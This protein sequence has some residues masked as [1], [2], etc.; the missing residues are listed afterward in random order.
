MKGAKI[1]AGKSQG[2]RLVTTISVL[3]ISEPELYSRMPIKGEYSGNELVLTSFAQIADSVEKQLEILSVLHQHNQLGIIL[4]YVG[5]ILPEVSEKVIAKMDEL[6]MVLIL[7]PTNRMDLRYSEVISEALVHISEEE[8]D[9]DQWQEVLL[10]TIRQ[11]PA[12]NQI[13]TSLSILSDKFKCSLFIKSQEDEV[14][15]SKA[16]PRSLDHDLRG[17]I[18]G[19]QVNQSKKNVALELKQNYYFQTDSR[20]ALSTF[21]QSYYLS[22]FRREPIVD[23]QLKVIQRIVEKTIRYFGEEQL[24]N[25]GQQFFSACQ[26]GDFQTASLLAQKEGIDLTQPLRVHCQQ[27]VRPKKQPVY[28][29]K[30][31]YYQEQDLA[32]L[33]TNA[34]DQPNL[35]EV[36]RSESDYYFVSREFLG[37]D[38][39]FEQM[40]LIAEQIE[41]GKK[42]FPTKCYFSSEDLYLLKDVTRET[43]RIFLEQFLDEEL[44]ETLAVFFLD[45]NE[46]I[47]ETSA[48]IFLHN[49]TIKYRLKRAQERLGL[50]FSHISSRYLLIKNL[51]YYR[52]Y[53]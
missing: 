12:P 13:E 32:W 15:L 20:L 9:L 2:Q 46:S 26:T 6:E 7:M 44:I 43:E 27:I 17:I 11:L 33:L 51:I 19:R 29:I 45:C 31:M 28:R 8:A 14:L 39:V 47:N 16:W 10:E 23:K 5:L 21:S 48:Q 40:T 18:A 24:L 52:K 30:G 25:I 50:S 37:L 22:L 53:K 36:S 1:I 49:N 34:S 3:E 42:V 41:D 4:Y 38:T 35:A